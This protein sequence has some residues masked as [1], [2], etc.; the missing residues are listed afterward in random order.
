MT[1]ARRFR[2]ICAPL[3]A[4]AKADVIGRKDALIASGLSTKAVRDSKLAPMLAAMRWSVA[5]GAL[6]ANPAESVTATVRKTGGGRRGF[7]D[8]E[9]RKAL[10]V[11]ARETA[12]HLKWLPILCA[13]TGARLPELCQ[14]RGADAQ[15]EGAFGFSI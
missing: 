4:S 5:N 13:L 7:N 14:F 9:A 3:S 6:S 1:S 2:P 11:A 15:R 8:D 12:P 10:A